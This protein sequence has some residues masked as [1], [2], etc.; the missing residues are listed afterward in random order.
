MVTLLIAM[1]ALLGLNQRT[2]F[3]KLP[4][5]PEFSLCDFVVA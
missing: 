5:F 1:G 4:C 2:L 3:R